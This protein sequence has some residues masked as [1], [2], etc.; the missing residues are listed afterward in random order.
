MAKVKTGGDGKFL[1][2]KFRLNS[3]ILNTLLI[4]LFSNLVFIGCQ[5]YH[6][7]QTGRQ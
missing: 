3:L 6:T 7:D 1:L 4:L 2:E 5:Q